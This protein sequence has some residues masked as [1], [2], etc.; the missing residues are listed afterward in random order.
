MKLLVLGN[1]NTGNGHLQPG[2][3]EW[4]VLVARECQARL[5][6]PVEC[7]NRTFMPM[8][9]RAVPYAR[10]LV[11]E[12]D[13]DLVIIPLVIYHCSVGWVSLKVRQ[14]VGERAYGW[15]RSIEGRLTHSPAPLGRPG[16]PPRSLG[17]RVL[18]RLIG[19][20]THTT[21]DDVIATYTELLHELARDEGRHVLV[22]GESHYGGRVRRENPTLQAIVERAEAA[23]RPV[24]EKHRFLWADVHLAH[25]AGPGS[26]ACQSPDGIH[27]NAT[28]HRI[29]AETVMAAAA[30]V[31]AER[32]G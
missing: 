3:I 22:V 31:L 1:S 29:F 26:E 25:E 5:G 16:S 14:R 9:A 24:I 12:N 4:P 11:D 13:P 8:G 30:P 21:V 7:E 6:E 18:R 20:A 2:E 23:I 27:V 10:K 32:A 28:G 17:R 15:Y 19:T